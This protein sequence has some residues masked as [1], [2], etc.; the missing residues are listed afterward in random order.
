MMEQ[1]DNAA[2]YYDQALHSVSDTVSQFYRAI[3]TRQAFLSYE[4][5]HVPD[6]SLAELYRL[7]SQ[8][9]NDNELV[10]RYLV[11]GDIYYYER[12][13]DSAWVYLK[14]VYD[15]TTNADSKMLSTERLQELSL[16]KGDSLSAKEYALEHS[17]LVTVKDLDG[18]LHSQLTALCQHYEQNRQ[19]AVHKLKRQKDI[20][21]WSIV[22][23]IL[24]S[25]VV[26]A[27]SLLML[28]RKRNKQLQNENDDVGKLLE[29]ERQTHKIQQAALSGRLRQSNVALRDVSRQLEKTIA[30][31][32]FLDVSAN[33]DDY[34]SYINAPICQ[35][36]ITLVHK[37]QFKSKMDCLIY[38]D[39]A[40]SKEQLLALRK[41]AEKT[42][43]RFTAQIR[44]QF[45]GLTDGDMDY[46]Y[47]FLLGLN[48][49]DVSALMQRA[50]TTVCD[51]SRKISRTIGAN[52]SLDHTLR[53]LLSER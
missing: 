23:V 47:L 21:R 40:L 14:W 22:L 50:Y 25:V 3:A 30:N 27:I 13:Y 12:Q 26:V 44:Q 32:V 48:E 34:S 31:N 4:R 49:A 28:S 2:Y 16:I 19:E 38:K 43:P 52:G 42:L 53:N 35:Y 51:R 18:K 33:P 36:L 20:K 46:C 8:A 37:Q 5:E 11:L 17:Q 10:S 6:K 1:Y 15:N 39:F 41:A 29:S 45:P 7:A 24:L 9:E